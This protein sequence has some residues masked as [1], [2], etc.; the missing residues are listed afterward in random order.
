MS[1]ETRQKKIDRLFAVIEKKPTPWHTV[2]H[3]KQNENGERELFY[4]LEEK[5]LLQD[6]IIVTSTNS[7]LRGG[8]SII[9]VTP[10]YLEPIYRAAFDKFESQY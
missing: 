9:E 4:K 6:V 1:K 8:A 2:T 5:D 10:K 3:Y 7:Q